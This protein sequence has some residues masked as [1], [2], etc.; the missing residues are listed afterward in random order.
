MAVL[1][2]QHI[3]ICALKKDRKKILELLQRMEMIEICDVMKEDILFQK[4]DLSNS[5]TIFEKNVSIANNALEI[6]GS[7]VKEDKS[8]LSSFSGRTVTPP[9]AY[10]SFR[11]KYEEILKIA[12][13][14]SACAKQIAEAKAEIIKLQEQLEMLKPWLNLDIP[15]GFK[16]TKSTVVHI[17]TL[18]NEWS[19]EQLYME[20]ASCMP[21]HLEV[22][23]KSKEQTCAFVLCM[24]EVSEQV[25]ENLRRI[26]FAKPSYS[27]KI[28]PAAYQEELSDMI[29][30][31]QQEM[32][33]AKQLIIKMSEQR[34]NIKFLADYD[35]MRAEKYEVIGHLLQ[36]RNVFVLTGY[37]AERDKS[38]VEEALNSSFDVAVSYSDVS[39]DEDVPIKLQN[40]AFSK[41]IESVIE[42]YSAPG[43]GEADPTVPVSL[44]YYMFYGLMF[45]DAGYGA[46]MSVA[47]AIILK[48][49]KNMEKGAKNMIQMFFYCGL[50]TIFWGV[51][52]GSYFGDA[53]DVIAK[54]F[55]NSNFTIPALWFYPSSEPMRMLTF[56]MLLGLIHL[57]TGMG[58]KGLQFV[59]QKD[60]KGLVY[61]VIS[62]YLLLIGCILALL[63]MQMFADILGLSFVLPAICSM[64]GAVLAI[65]GG[66]LIILTNG[67]ESI[68][69]F[70]RI[71]KGLYALYGV[72]GYLSDVLSYSRLLALGL[73]TGVIGSVINKMGSMAGGSIAGVV[74][75]IPVFIGGHL[76]NIAINALGAYVHTNRLQYV[77]FFGKFYEGGGRMF[78]PFNV[79]TKYYKFKEK[80][81][82]G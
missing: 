18:P 19:E 69:P 27:S 79:N 78:S 63:S 58:L 12:K 55:F 77:E 53:V 41:P 2:M 26:G 6:L 82:N 52:F 43:K 74:L 51:I 40:N 35:F 66:S 49:N 30:K 42:A 54:T 38:A 46:L 13:K 57:F 32:E 65:V 24:K 11:S 5:K 73:A 36:T 29:L 31:M 20:L 72:T 48:K 61:D 71:L 76:L 56:S 59:R 47:C 34:D 37:I 23:S 9:A 62:W 75:F 4:M 45:S 70:K 33:D 81:N 64:I 67:R 39:E 1:Q 22:I 16:G 60:Y 25:I 68:N 80:I 7:Y 28:A 21:V 17:G 8:M 3:S 15:I 14:I 44:F 10:D 50:A